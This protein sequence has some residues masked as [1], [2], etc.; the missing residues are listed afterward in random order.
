MNQWLLIRGIVGVLFG[1]VALLWPGITLLALIVLFGVYAFIDG[2]VNLVLGFTSPASHGRWLQVAEGV[3]GIVL[4]I[5]A[6]V[7]PGVTLLALVFLVAA[8]AIIEGVLEIVAAIRLR[9]VLQREWLLA[10]AGILSIAFGVL[11]VAFPGAGALSI[12]W[13]LGIYA[14]AAGIVRIVLWNRLRQP[15]VTF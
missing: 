3:V 7:W 5:V 14:I 15:V 1:I 4:G 12:A 2:V 11:V 9:Q 10:L 8:W 13:L 6:L